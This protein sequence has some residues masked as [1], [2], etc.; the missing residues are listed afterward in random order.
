M[1]GLPLERDAPRVTVAPLRAT[2]NAIDAPFVRWFDGAQTNA[3]FNELDRHMLTGHAGEM[4]F[5]CEPDDDKQLPARVSRR[6][7]L[8]D[9]ALAARAAS[10][11]APAGVGL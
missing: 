10:P 7:L 8:I 4:A 3:A 2:V 5:M 6:E 1:A 11:V 9:S